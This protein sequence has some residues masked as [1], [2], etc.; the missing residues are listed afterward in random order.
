MNKKG[1][2]LSMNV[3]IIAILVILVLVIVAA[4]FV[5]GIGHLVDII[6]GVAP[7]DQSTAAS[8]CSSKCDLAQVLNEATKKNAEYCTKTWK[9]DENGDGKIDVDAEGNIKRYHCY[10]SP[11][12]VRCPGVEDFCEKQ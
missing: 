5:G 4:F 9:F 8:T 12:S 6:R 7:D 2:E 10:D 3:V 11:I 1:V